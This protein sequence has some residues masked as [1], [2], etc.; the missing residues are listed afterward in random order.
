VSPGAVLAGKDP[1]EAIDGTFVT[2][3][4]VGMNDDVAK[5]RQPMFSDQ[6]DSSRRSLAFSWLW[7]MRSQ[8]CSIE[9]PPSFSAIC[10]RV[11]LGGIAWAAVFQSSVSRLWENCHL[12][13]PSGC[14][15]HVHDYAYKVAMNVIVGS[16]LAGH[17]LRFNPKK[18][19]T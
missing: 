4:T 6:R 3:L 5:R 8:G 16:T 19:K 17:N 13:L 1:L 10:C 11:T 15:F 14:L 18:A 12:A 9:C 2:A 7:L